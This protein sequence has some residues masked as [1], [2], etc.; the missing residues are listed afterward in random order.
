M[1]ETILQFGGGNFLRAFVDVF[2]HEANAAGER[3]G[4]IVVV[5]STEG[6]RAALLNAQ[7]GTYHVVFRGL[8]NGVAIDRTLAVRSISR[9]LIAKSEWSKVVHVARS[10]A[11][12]MVVSNTTEAGYSLVDDDDPDMPLSFPARLLCVLNAR[13]RAG[14]PG[15]SVLPCELVEPNGELLRELVLAQA[16]AWGLDAGLQG[17]IRRDVRWV[18]T[19]VDRIV[20]GRPDSHP[21]LASDGLLT[22]AEP[23]ALWVVEARA[24][25]LFE[26]PSVRYVPDVR[27]YALRKVR[28]LNGAHTS[29]VCK[30]GP[31]GLRTVR[32]AVGDPAV[33]GWLR[34]LVFEEIVPTLEHVVEDAR[35]FAE[36]VLERFAN[37][38]LDH[39]LEDIALHHDEKVKVRLA[40]TYEAFLKAFGRPPEL[41]GEILAPY[42]D[43]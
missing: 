31:S 29:L 40:P 42:R 21:L 27:P 1:P 5:Q 26:H 43:A 10:P 8:A 2:V 28:I 9:A 12:R 16:Q 14:L 32:E 11:L 35:P 41:L 38:F 17:W 39:R 30:A 6:N 37:P 7:D 4:R 36:Q 20:S 13:Y 33:G 3:V 19:L 23:F 24:E 34:R 22:A 25:D 18:N 15:L